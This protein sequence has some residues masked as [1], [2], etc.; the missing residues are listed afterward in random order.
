LG[1]LVGSGVYVGC[2]VFVGAG[3]FVG[4]GVSVGTGVLVG[5]G[6]FVG[7]ACACETPHPAIVTSK[8]NNITTKAAF[9]ISHLLV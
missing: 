3:V 8:T 6:V 5:T 9:F 4:T 1:V 7:V 2:G